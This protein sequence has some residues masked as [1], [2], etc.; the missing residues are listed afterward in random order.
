MASSPSSSSVPGAAEGEVDAVVQ[1]PMPTPSAR[2]QEEATPR[3]TPAHPADSQDEQPSPR[4]SPGCSA[5]ARH[6]LARGE[7]QGQPGHQEQRR[8]RRRPGCS[9]STRS[10]PAR[11]WCCRRSA[12]R[13]LAGRRL[14]PDLLVEPRPA[15]AS[16]S[17][18]RPSPRDEDQAGRACDRSEEHPREDLLVEASG[19]CARSPSISAGRPAAAAVARPGR[20]LPGAVAHQIGERERGR[21][22][23]GIAATSPRALAR[24]RE[25]GRLGP[26]APVPALEHQVELVEPDRLLLEPATSWTIGWSGRKS[27]VQPSSIRR[28]RSPGTRSSDSTTGT[29]ARE[30]CRRPPGTGRR[31][32]A[33]GPG[34]HQREDGGHQGDADHPGDAEADAGQRARRPAAPG[35]PSPGTRRT[36]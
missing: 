25:Q 28:R 1:R 21:D 13:P 23:P 31:S 11:A 7:A 34:W 20:P 5:A 14:A 26:R 6:P 17:R 15:S 16:R 4:R 32:I 3:G 36:R 12:P 30:R 27:R 29:P 22:A 19:R 9:R 35:S 8:A 2:K 10:G 24:A 18:S 33:A